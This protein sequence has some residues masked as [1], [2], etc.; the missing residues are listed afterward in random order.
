MANLVEMELSKRQAKAQAPKKEVASRFRMDALQKTIETRRA[1]AIKLGD[2]IYCGYWEGGAPQYLK[3]EFGKA[4]DKLEKAEKRLKAKVAEIEER[5]HI[6]NK[7]FDEKYNIQQGEKL[8]KNKSYKAF[9]KLK[10][11]AKQAELDKLNAESYKIQNS[12]LARLVAGHKA[13]GGDE[14]DAVKEI[15]AA[16]KEAGHDLDFKNIKLSEKDN[17]WSQTF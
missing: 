4:D 10:L 3:S 1:Q 15:Q 12:F 6:T 9:A 5:A 7:L 8:K 14:R 16:V 13:A 17:Q 2:D 11:E